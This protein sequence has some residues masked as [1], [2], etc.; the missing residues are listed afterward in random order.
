[1]STTYVKRNIASNLIVAGAAWNFQLLTTTGTVATSSV[2]VPGGGGTTSGY[3]FTQAGVPGTDGTAGNYT[4]T[5]NVMTAHNQVSLRVQ[6]ARVSSTGAVQAESTLSPELPGGTGEKMHTFTN[7]NLGTWTSGDRLRVRLQFVNS[8][9]QA[10]SVSVTH[11][12]G[13]TATVAPWSL[14][15]TTAPTLTSTGKTTTSVSLSAT[16]IAGADS[17]RFQRKLSGTGDETYATIQDTLVRTVTDTGRLN[18]TSYTYRVQARNSAGDGPWS[19]ALVVVTN[20]LGTPTLS[21]PEKTDTT[22]SMV[23]T[24]VTEAAT[25]ELQRDTITV[26]NTS[27]TSFSDTGLDPNTLYTYRVRAVNTGGT[28]EWSTLQVQTEAPPPSDTPTIYPTV[29]SNDQSKLLNSETPITFSSTPITDQPTVIEVDTSVL[30]QRIVGFGA[31]MTEAAGVVLDDLAPAVRDQLMQELF[32]PS[33]A[34]LSFLRLPLGASDYGLGDY[35]YADVQGPS[36]DPLANFSIAREDLYVVPRLQQALAINPQ[37]KFMASPWSAPAWM[38]QNNTLKGD[39]GGPLLDIWMPTY[40][41]Y[42]VRYVQEMAARG[43]TIDY[44]TPQ[45]EPGF[46]PSYIG[47][48]MTVA[49]Q[50]EFVRDHLRP[51][52]NAAGV[53]TQ[54]IGYDHNWDTTA[55]PLALLNDPG[56]KEALGGIAWHGYLGEPSGQSVVRDAHPDVDQFFTEITEFGTANFS[57]DLRWNTRTIT[58]GSLS[59]WARTAA[60]WNLVL[61]TNFGPINGGASDLRGLAQVDRVADTY[62]FQPAYYSLAQ[63]SRFIIQGSVRVGRFSSNPWNIIH[64]EAYLTPESDI[65]LH[66]LNDGGTPQLCTVKWNGFEAEVE[67]ATGVNTLVWPSGLEFPEPYTSGSNLA[68]GTGPVIDLQN[69][70]ANTFS[71]QFDFEAEFEEVNPYTFGSNIVSGVVLAGS[72]EVIQVDT[73]SAEFSFGAAQLEPIVS[74]IE[75]LAADQLSLLYTFGEPELYMPEIGAPPVPTGIQVTVDGTSLIFTGYMVGIPTA[76]AVLMEDGSEALMEDGSPILM[77][78]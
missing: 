59:H 27:A 53:P 54:I 1:M 29:T 41:E 10:Q 70:Q 16:E 42:F 32:G 28:G 14:P 2:G 58:I 24:T 5:V 61:D 22:T 19:T 55:Y 36:G 43:I 18:T 50:I 3:Y 6:V 68:T 52:F 25:Y 4:V 51:A 69:V 46:A 71:V 35:T 11:N 60:T 15:I 47:M 39:T 62:E 26:Q 64:T 67:L 38:R 78:V 30:R 37:I 20:T 31:A 66:V 49:Q 7:P 12:G 9:M 76:N 63:A 21:N 77:E 34:R 74:G 13:N 65:V 40:A 44:V 72:V 45:N 8:H 56:T 48:T 33:G 75:S 17:Y 57:E 23:W 73:F